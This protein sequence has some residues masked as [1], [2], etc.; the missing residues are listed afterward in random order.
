M[1]DRCVM[2]KIIDF[3]VASEHI[4]CKSGLANYLRQI[5]DYIDDDAIE[6][7]PTAITMVLTSEHQ[8]EVLNIGYS[9]KADFQD[10]ASSAYKYSTVPYQRRGGN[11]FPRN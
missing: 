2:A 11:K 7:G 6:C 10:A 4:R 3:P 9:T 1:S 5:A 8:H